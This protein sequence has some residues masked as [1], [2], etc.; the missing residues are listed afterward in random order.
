V[1]KNP[2]LEIAG[3]GFELE[4]DETGNLRAL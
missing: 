2:D 4:F 1:T 3:P